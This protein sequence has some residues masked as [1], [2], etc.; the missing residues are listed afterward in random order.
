[1]S[2]LGTLLTSIDTKL[3]TVS[4]ITNPDN[5]IIGETIDIFSKNETFF[6]RLEILIDK[7]KFD[8]SVGQRGVDHSYRFTIG[9]FLRR[10]RHDVNLTQ[11][12]NLV[13]FGENVVSKIVSFKDDRIHGNPPV[14]GFL[15]VSNFTEIWYEFELVE[16]I[17]TFVTAFSIDVNTTDT[18][19]Q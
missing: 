4:E 5:V 11:M 1:M 17:S 16:K 3:K 12:L 15:T 2:S 14:P 13:Q 6:P 9:G 10:D 18:I 19:N 7:D 8:G